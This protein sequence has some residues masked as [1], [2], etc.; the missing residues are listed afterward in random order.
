MENQCTPG[1]KDSARIRIATYVALAIMGILVIMAAASAR[2][3]P[4]IRKHPRAFV[5]ELVALGI[6]TALPMFVFVW[7]RG[8]TVKKCALVVLLFSIKLAILHTLL[9]IGGFYQA[10]M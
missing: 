2:H 9:E 7:T 1:K 4:F 8:V 10:V 6:V 3:V 5:F